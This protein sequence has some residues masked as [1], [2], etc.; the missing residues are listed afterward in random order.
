MRCWTHSTKRLES[1]ESCEACRRAYDNAASLCAHCGRMVTNGAFFKKT[2]PHLNLTCRP[3]KAFPDKIPEQSWKS[4][5]PYPMPAAESF[6]NR[7]IRTGIY[8]LEDWHKYWKLDAFK[9][10]NDNQVRENLIAALEQQN[11]LLR[12]ILKEQTP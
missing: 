2:S 11:A 3:E 8:T 5:L 12:Q 7:Q 6:E 1:G 9:A 10:D 4:K